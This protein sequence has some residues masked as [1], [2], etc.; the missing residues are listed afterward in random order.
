MQVVSFI[1]TNESVNSVCLCL[2]CKWFLV[3]GEEMA[4]TRSGPLLNLNL[5]LIVR[6]NPKRRMMTIRMQ[7]RSQISSAVTEL[8]IGAENLQN[9]DDKHDKDTSTWPPGTIE[10]VEKD[11]ADT[12]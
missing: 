3:M 10:H 12:K 6:R 5:I 7:E 9:E 1:S 8:E 4:Q 11:E 2:A